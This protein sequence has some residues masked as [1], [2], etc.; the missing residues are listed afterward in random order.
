MR[1]I[2]NLQTATSRRR[3]I[4][5]SFSSP[6]A[7][8]VAVTAIIA[9]VLVLL[10]SLVAWL[11]YRT[12]RQSAVQDTAANANA[13]ATNA[14]TFLS[15]RLQLLRAVARADVVRRGNL[16][17]IDRYFSE[18][19]E[20]GLFGGGI[21]FVDA[22]SVLRIVSGVDGAAATPLDISD[23]DY[24]RAMAAGESRFISEA[25]VGR[26]VQHP[27]VVLAVPVHDADGALAGSLAGSIRLDLGGG[28]LGDLGLLDGE[29]EIVD[30]A[31]QL[32]VAG[33]PIDELR[34]VDDPS[35][36]QR[37]RETGAG[38]EVDVTGLTGEPGQL[39]GYAAAP[40]GEWIVVV[41]RPT[42]SVLGPARSM[43]AIQVA[44]LITIAMLGL[45]AAWRIGRRLD[46][47]QAER[48]ELLRRERA[49]RGSLERIQSV[50]DAALSTLDFHELVDALLGKVRTAVEADAATLM[51]VS[52]DGS[53]LDEIASE[54]PAR[55]PEPSSVPIGQGIAGKIVAAGESIVVDDLSTYEIVRPW[56]RDT[57]RSFAGVPLLR[58]DTVVGV[59]HVS[60][61]RFRHFEDD[62]LA[63][64]RLV[65]GRVVSALER[66]RLYEQRDRMARELQRPL[67][68][69]TLPSMPHAQLAGFYRP[70]AQGDDIGGDFYDGFPLDDD[71]W[72]LVIGDVMGKGPE[73]AAVMGFARHTIRAASMFVS[74]PSRVLHALNELLVSSAQA[75]DRF[76]T[77][78]YVRLRPN[79]GVIRLTAS[80]AGHPLPIILRGDGRLERCGV[81]GTL[82]GVFDDP[83]LRDRATD[84][85]PGDALLL[86][87][88]GL[89]ERREGDVDDRLERVLRSVA[90]APAPQIV[91]AIE[92][93]VIVPSDTRDDIA[94]VVLTVNRTGS[95]A[96]TPPS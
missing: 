82:L 72:G 19:N 21:G 78:C 47:S 73:A 62:E 92:D 45:A 15:E 37:L 36:V 83:D 53:T 57:M 38:V 85:H 80:V 54:G 67:I 56:L 23:R 31:G 35:R 65:A 69:E 14:Q 10:G 28:A 60:S 22:D 95:G 91:R 94:C 96:A 16:D 29:V 42:A 18:I 32:I 20:A 17:Q 58:R 39:L 24:A 89:V 27:M 40:L 46:G 4:R 11:G 1:P 51:L 26:V 76:C 52:V 66:S 75:G 2:E 90:G 81:P 9:F 49:A 50:T 77:A 55:P 86:Y 74:R 34:G 7:R 44:T 25:I 64:L 68:P 8:L 3:Q 48:E 13:A 41:E 84:L 71:A 61:T 6:G 70:L 43:L 79:D 87:T 59:L 30:R 93:E 12:E 5:P 88:D 33:G 63:L